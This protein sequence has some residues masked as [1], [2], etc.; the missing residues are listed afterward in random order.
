[1]RN[2]KP[3]PSAWPRWPGGV[4]LDFGRGSSLRTSLALCRRTS[5]SSPASTSS[6][7]G[8]RSAN[9]RPGKATSFVVLPNMKRKSQ[10]TPACMACW[11]SLGHCSVPQRSG[12]WGR[13]HPAVR[14]PSNPRSQRHRDHRLRLLARNDAF[15]PVGRTGAMR[16]GNAGVHW[17]ERAF[18]TRSPFL[19]R[20]CAARRLAEGQRSNS[21]ALS[22]AATLS[23]PRW[24]TVRT[25]TSDRPWRRP[26]E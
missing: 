15:P 11:W 2:S 4:P 1:M 22:S 17:V 16:R 7:R 24:L 3:Q 5:E 8:Q 21:A 26:V 23:L 13:S 18:L 6:L 14:I 10:I 12:H 25:R 9:P 20:H 19:F